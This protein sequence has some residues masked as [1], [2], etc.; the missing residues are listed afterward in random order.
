MSDKESSD[1]DQ[2]QR[3]MAQMVADASYVGVKELIREL[4][5]SRGTVQAD[6]RDLEAAGQVRR[7]WGGAQPATKTA[8]RTAD[9][10]SAGPVAVAA[11]LVRS[12]DAILLACGDLSDALA[13]SLVERSDIASLR[14]LTGDVRA[15]ARFAEDPVRFSVLV[16][17]GTLR[18]TVLVSDDI[19]P[20]HD[21]PVD[22]AFLPCHRISAG[23]QVFLTEEQSAIAAS[24]V[25]VAARRRVLVS[26]VDVFAASGGK[27]WLS[28]SEFDAVITGAVR[29][30]SLLAGLR[31]AGAQIL[32]SD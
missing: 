11:A 27:K 29:D 3:R 26:D 10:V 17:G 16:T 18:G 19:A 12:Q 23:G 5:V 13:A 22:I 6:L 25:A 2:R 30:R 32:V 15:C 31:S 1:R 7:V 28:L 21:E 8:P 4:R 20:Q 14:V 24:S 9:P